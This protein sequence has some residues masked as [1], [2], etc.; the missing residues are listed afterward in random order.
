MQPFHCCLTILN[1]NIE[2]L[3]KTNEKEKLGGFCCSCEH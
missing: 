1:K 3:T 2:N